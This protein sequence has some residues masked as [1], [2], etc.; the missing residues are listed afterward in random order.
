MPDGLY[1]RDALA[2]AEQQAGLL[3]RVAAGELVNDAVDWANVIEEVADVGLS[4]LRACRSLLRQAMVHLLKLQA[5]PDSPAAPHWRGEVVGFLDDA[6]D[7]F[8]PSMRQRVDVQELYRGAL[9][10]VRS[11]AEDTREMMAV[12]EVCPFKLEELVDG[13]LEVRE[14]MAKL[15]NG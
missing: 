1:G 4:E 6:R 13:T 8:T 5:W 12:P 11:E 10:R 15:P 14:L 7:R 3:R 2:W 9:R